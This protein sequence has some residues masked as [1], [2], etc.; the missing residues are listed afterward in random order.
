LKPGELGLSLRAL[1]R[2]EQSKA[3]VQGGLLIEGVEGPAA[4]AGLVPGDV[5]LAINGVTVNSVEQVRR[6]MDKKPRSVA[7]LILHDGDRIFVPVELD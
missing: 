5:L 4:R 2:D 3:H 6:L 1:T 7:L